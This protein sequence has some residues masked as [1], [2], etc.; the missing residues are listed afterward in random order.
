MNRS[1][2][3]IFEISSYIKETISFYGQIQMSDKLIML[4]IKLK[5]IKY[6]L[7]SENETSA[8]HRAE[9]DVLKSTIKELT[10]GQIYVLQQQHQGTE[11]AVNK[12]IREELAVKL[13]QNNT[14]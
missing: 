4:D 3:S 7:R 10:T 9:I 12:D 6:Q 8:K 11:V 2:Q 13:G 1:K 5:K 14:N